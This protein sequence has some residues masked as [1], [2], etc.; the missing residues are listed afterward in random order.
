MEENGSY[1]WVP[2]K[3]PKEKKK[4]DF[5]RFGKTAL[6]IVLFLVIVMGALTAVSFVV[7]IVMANESLY[8]IPGQRF[9]EDLIADMVGNGTRLCSRLR[10]LKHPADHLQDAVRHFLPAGKAAAPD[11][12]RS[13]KEL[14]QRT[15]CIIPK[16]FAAV[17]LQNAVSLKADKHILKPFRTCLPAMEDPR[18]HNKHASPRKGNALSVS[19]IISAA[20][21]GQNDLQK[22]VPMLACVFQ[23]HRGNADISAL[24]TLT[25]VST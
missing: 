24:H 23:M 10:A 1:S 4:P 15:V 6:V 13:G 20:L 16:A 14:F 17:C 7:G 25:S 22:V 19:K 2:P 21:Q 18:L 8:A 11:T 3:A 5:K 12:V 9:R